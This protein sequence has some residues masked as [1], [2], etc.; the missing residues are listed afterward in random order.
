MPNGFFVMRAFGLTSGLVNGDAG[1][2]T[3]GV[4]VL[5]LVFA[6]AAMAVLLFCVGRLFALLL[7]VVIAGLE[8][9]THNIIP[10]LMSTATPTKARISQVVLCLRGGCSMGI[11]WGNPGEK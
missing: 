1:F 7:F 4:D 3:A 11:F 8:K 2:M 6:F 10:T 9:P 5:A